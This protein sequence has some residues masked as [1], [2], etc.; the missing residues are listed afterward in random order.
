M[1]TMVNY[2]LNDSFCAE[3]I[4]RRVF[5]QCYH[6]ICNMSKCICAFILSR[7]PFKREVSFF[8]LAFSLRVNWWNICIDDR[9]YRIISYF[10]SAWVEKIVLKHA[11]SP[12]S[13]LLTKQC[14]GIRLCYVGARYS[15]KNFKKFCWLLLKSC[16]KIVS[17]HFF[18]PW[19]YNNDGNMKLMF[20]LILYPTF[21]RNCQENCKK[22]KETLVFEL[23]SKCMTTTL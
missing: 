20:Q 2:S 14:N 22:G 11:S 17:S 21:V 4:T 12:F 16:S 8:L 10:L 1:K 15:Y 18:P 5:N 9:W 19:A 7:G 23:P 6:S 3:L 13:C